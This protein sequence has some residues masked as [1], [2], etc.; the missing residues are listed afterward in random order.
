MLKRSDLIQRSTSWFYK[1]R[2]LQKENNSLTRLRYKKKF[3][4]IND[5]FNFYSQA[6]FKLDF[7]CHNNNFNV[8]ISNH[9][10]YF[11]YMK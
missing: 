4:L 8:L 1:T 7:L 9:V 6:S 10:A 5:F 11:D 3:P 2:K